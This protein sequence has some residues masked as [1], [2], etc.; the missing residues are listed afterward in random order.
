MLRSNTSW[1]FFDK[2]GYKEPTTDEEE[3][4][5]YEMFEKSS[6]KDAPS[7]YAPTRG[8]LKVGI[9]LKNIA[10]Q[11]KKFISRLFS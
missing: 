8:S 7:I 10:V 9:Q 1:I 4:R 5:E 2:E 6:G 11:F 3:T